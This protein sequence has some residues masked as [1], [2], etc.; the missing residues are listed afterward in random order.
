V[1]LEACRLH[2]TG[3]LFKASSES[4]PAMTAEGQL[5]SSGV[6]SMFEGVQSHFD[7]HTD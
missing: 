4:L 6:V 7:D 5:W 3:A 2:L 1:L